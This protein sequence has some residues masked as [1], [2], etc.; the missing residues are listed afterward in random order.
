M[1][2]DV[3]SVAF[4]T[5]LDQVNGP[6]SLGLQLEVT[7]VRLNDDEQAILDGREGPAV[8]QV[9]NVPAKGEYCTWMEK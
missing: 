6:V 4:A 1:S 7:G 2:G 3:Y 5:T 8:Q 9:G